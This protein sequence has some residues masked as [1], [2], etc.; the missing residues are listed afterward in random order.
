MKRR[1]VI[2]CGLVKKVFR[3][4]QNSEKREEEDSPPALPVREEAECSEQAS[5]LL[6]FLF[7][8]SS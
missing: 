1:A 2:M 3:A 4:S 8:C 6:A 7:D 5:A